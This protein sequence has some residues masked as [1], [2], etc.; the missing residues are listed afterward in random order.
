MPAWMALPAYSTVL[1]TYANLASWQAATNSVQTADFEGLAPAGSYTTYNTPTGVSSY[2]GV[3]FIGLNSTGSY[4]IQVIDTSAFS[5]YNFNTHD[6]LFQTMDRGSGA[7]DPYIHVVFTVPIT[8]FAA[9]L[10]TT[11]PSALNYSITLYSGPT[12]QLGSS[13]T[14]PTNSQPNTAFWGITSD[15]PIDHADFMVPGTIF[16]G[17]T[18]IFLDNFRYGAGQPLVDE[19]PEAATMLLIGSGLIGL[20]YLR[21]RMGKCARA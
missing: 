3:E 15:T 21:K 10:F 8:A 12:T 13:Y 14:V 16:N 17:G 7:Q 1:T 2:P 19:T 9:D 18:H 11:G 4:F 20:A 6:A 5:W